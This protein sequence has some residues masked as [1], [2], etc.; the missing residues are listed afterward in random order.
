MKSLA[1]DGDS[2]AGALGASASASASEFGASASRVSWT[3]D[4]TL[5]R[6]S[7]TTREGE[8]GA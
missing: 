8:P 3:M 1:R 4:R 7:D 6:P 5:R 2:D